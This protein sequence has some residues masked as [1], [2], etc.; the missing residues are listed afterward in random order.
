VTNFSFQPSLFYNWD[1]FL[2]LPTNRKLYE[3]FKNLNLSRFEDK[4]YGHGQTGYSR[5]AMIKALIVK[6]IAQ[7]KSIPRLIEYLKDN[8]FTCDLCGFDN[9]QIPD[10]TQFYRLM[11]SLHSSKLSDLL[12]EVA[13]EIYELSKS[14]IQS[15]SLDSKSV[16]APTRQNNP[17]HHNRNLT[18]K[19]KKPKRNPEAT[20]GY[21]ATHVD[22]TGE[23][24]TDLRWGYRTHS[25]IDNA[26]GI[27]LVEITVPINLPDNKIAKLLFKE[28]TKRYDLSQLRNIFGDK[29]Y[30][31]KKL[32]A[33]IRNLLSSSLERPEDINFLIGKNCRNAKGA[34]PLFQGL[35]C[36]TGLL[37]KFNG[38]LPANKAGSA[39]RMKFRCPLALSKS[40]FTC[41]ISHP[42]LTTGKHYGCTKYIPLSADQAK[43]IRALIDDRKLR[44]SKPARIRVRIER[45]FSRLQAITSEDAP[46][47]SKRSV[48][49]HVSLA[50]ITLSLIALTALKLGKPDKINSYLKFAA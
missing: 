30:D 42:A 24:I 46:Y 47:Y 44:R 19:H 26:L 38:L 37:M 23:R 16:L 14:S 6:N 22:H 5:H 43:I 21:Y 18:N 3:L 1:F 25:I 20:L 13:N 36:P 29:A 40:D 50:H 49:N 33:F 39:Y 7:L 17:K 34:S 32:K 4:N 35:P 48:R 2:N 15:I 11:K 45:Y 9:Y 8:P 41:P 27:T 31:D 28:L 12:A 10:D